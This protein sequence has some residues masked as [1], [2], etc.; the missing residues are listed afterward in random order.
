MGVPSSFECGVFPLSPSISMG[1]IEVY[2][3]MY[4]IVKQ[5][6]QY[7]SYCIVR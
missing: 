2:R 1:K 7:V 3:D 4:R 5:V 6:S